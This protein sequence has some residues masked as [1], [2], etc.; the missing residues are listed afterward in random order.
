MKKVH[1][2]SVSALM[3]LI[4]K[5]WCVFEIEIALNNRGLPQAEEASWEQGAEDIV[6]KNRA[7]YLPDDAALKAEIMRHHYDNLHVGYYT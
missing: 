4:W 2:K 5:A 3:N 1:K 6:C 7:I